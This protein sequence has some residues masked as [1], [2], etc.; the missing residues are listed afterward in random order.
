MTWKSRKSGAAQKWFP[1]REGSASQTQISIVWD[2]SV[3]YVRLRAAGSS[4]S[5]CMGPPATSIGQGMIGSQNKMN[6]R[7]MTGRRQRQL[8]L[9][10]SQASVLKVPC[11]SHPKTLHI[12]K[13]S[14]GLT[15]MA[16]TDLAK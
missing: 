10:N 1:S 2:I 5:A 14:Q 6:Y 8:G 16:H 12:T 13:S 3:A 4:I 7:A 11:Y 9:K 15:L